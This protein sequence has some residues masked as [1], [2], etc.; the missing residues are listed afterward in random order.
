MMTAD[1]QSHPDYNNL[2]ESLKALYSEKE[3]A[4]LG[5]DGRDRLMET[6]CYPEPEE[7]D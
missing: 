3:F 7:E 4:W 6:E 5:N 2:P 1:F